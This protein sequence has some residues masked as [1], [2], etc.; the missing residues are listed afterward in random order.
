MGLNIF[1]DASL[2][3]ATLSCSC[4]N[5]SD[6]RWPPKSLRRRDRHANRGLKSWVQ[7]QALGGPQ[8]SGKMQRFHFRSPNYIL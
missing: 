1:L 3:S 7:K 5:L 6:S 8:T 2:F 4:S